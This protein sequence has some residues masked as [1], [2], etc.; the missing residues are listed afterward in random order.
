[1]MSAV[2]QLPNM[3]TILRVLL[4]FPFVYFM[5]QQAYGVALAILFLAGL[6][7]SLDG[8]LARRFGWRSTFGSIADPV[9]DKVLLVTAF[10]TLGWGGHIPLWLVALIVLRDLYIFSGAIAYWFVVGKYEGKPTLISKACT[11]MLI[12][13]GLLTIANLVWPVI[14]D[15]VFESIIWLVVALCLVSLIQYTLIA[16]KG[17][18]SKQVKVAGSDHD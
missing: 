18:R 12:T 8:A 7:D 10:I 1:M 9:A 4:V 13:L 3:L 5:V 17:Y 6:T 14:A 2:R 11:F 15:W 16:I